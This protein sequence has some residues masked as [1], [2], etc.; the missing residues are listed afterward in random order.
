MIVLLGQAGGEKLGRLLRSRP[1][2][3][4]LYGPTRHPVQDLAWPYAVDNDMFNHRTDPEWWEAEGE[5]LWRLMVG[6]LMTLPRE[7]LFVL[8]P[9]VVYRWQPT[10]ERAALYIPRIH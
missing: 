9:D 5:A 1:D 3:G 2:L 6:K 8:A 10:L 7:P 4:S